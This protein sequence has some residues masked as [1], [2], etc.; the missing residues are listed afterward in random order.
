MQARARLLTHRADYTN[1]EKYSNGVDESYI[2]Y[3]LM[4]KVIM[5]C[6][7]I[8]SKTTEKNLRDNL[9][10]LPT[11]MALVKSNIPTYNQYFKENHSQLVARG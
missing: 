8:N 9:A 3:P 7:T 2:M 6:A 11:Y 5:I 10:A 4:Y 1:V